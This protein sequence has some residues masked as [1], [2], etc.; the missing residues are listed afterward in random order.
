MLRRLIYLA[1]FG[2]GV[3][4]LWPY[5]VWELKD[6]NPKTTSFIELRKKEAKEKRRKFRPVMTWR[7]LDT[8]APAFVHAV[9]LA[10]DDRFYEHHGF[11]AEQILIAIKRNWRKK[12]YVYG[13][14]TIT[15]QL[16]RTLYLR[17]R[18]TIVRKLKEAALT[19]YLEMLLPKKRILELYL[20]VAEWGPGIFG[21]EAAS[22]Y[23]FWK[24]VEELTADEAVALASI[25]PSPRRWSPFSESP[26]LVER[27]TNLMERMEKDG[28]NTADSWNNPAPSVEESSETATE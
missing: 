13:G 8:M 4:L 14:S 5:N 25:M 1:A 26:G 20:N 17:P 9:L 7:K 22:Q 12:R 11:D 21:A 15:Q 27:K 16:A 18:K 2:F 24:P 6:K 28:Y 19:A 3:Y 10:E 23:Y